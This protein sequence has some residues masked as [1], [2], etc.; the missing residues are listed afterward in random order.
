MNW[1]QWAVGVVVAYCVFRILRAGYFLIRRTKEKA[2]PCSTCTTGCDLKSL[3]KDDVK[4]CD[5]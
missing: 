2:S 3:K 4:E 5:N 1:Q